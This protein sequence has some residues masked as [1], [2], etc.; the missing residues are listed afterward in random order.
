VSGADHFFTD[1]VD[2]LRMGVNDY[3]DD[4]LA[5]EPEPATEEEAAP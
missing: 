2:Q 5:D 3:L 4:A 1:R